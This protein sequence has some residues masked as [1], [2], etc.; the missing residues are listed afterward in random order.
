LV[1]RKIQPAELGLLQGKWTPQ[2][3]N[4]GKWIRGPK[5]DVRFMEEGNGRAARAHS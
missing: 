1:R 5:E 2:R 4:L 3:R